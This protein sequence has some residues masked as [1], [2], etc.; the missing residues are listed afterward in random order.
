VVCVAGPAGI[1]K[2]RLADE[3]VAMARRRGVEV[4]SVFCESHASD[5]P[6]LVAA[7]LLREAALIT[8]LDNEAARAQVRAMF[9]DDSY[10]DVLLLYDLMGIRDPDTPPPHDPSRRAA[11][12][13]ERT[14][15]VCVVDPHP[16]GPLRHRGCAL[17]R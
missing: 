2:T 5:V 9:P 15:Q 17:D 11:T 3:A 16:T 14:D 1:G 7:G 4:F 13:V 6:F 8:E 12:A 10:D